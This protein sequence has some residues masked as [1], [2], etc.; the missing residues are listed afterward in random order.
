MAGSMLMRGTAKHTR[1]QI[2]DEL[3]RLKAQMNASGSANNGASVSIT[4]IHSGLMGALK[5]AAEVLREPAFPESEFEQVRQSSIGRIESQRS[6]PQALA[7]NAMNRHLLPYPPGDPRA[8][9][10]PDE[11]IADLKKATLADVRKFHAD[12]YGTSHAELAVVGDFDL[13]EVQKL[14]AELFGDWKSPARYAPLL[15]SWKHLEVVDQS[16]ETPDKTN[17]FFA[18]GTTLSIDQADPDYPALLFANTMIGGGGQ[19]RLFRRIRDKDG[20]SY[21]VQSAFAAGAL[22]KFGQFL[23]V[24]ICNPANILKVEAAFKDEMGKILGDGF[25]TDEV[26]TAKKAFL[27]ERQVGRAQDQGLARTLAHN[28]QY[29]WTMARD[30]DLDQKISALSAAEINAALKRH[31]NAGTI[32]IFKAGDFKKAGVS[33]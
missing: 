27:Q 11:S 10:T 6:E 29:G 2:Q 31:I 32:S 30:A 20:L 9:P 14:A 17:A 25:P 18:A 23:S 19:S 8:I 21:A 24:A 16:I 3:D 22:E 28:A 7:M 13:A 1:Q 5:L 4:T 33:Q 15:R 26:E 12:F